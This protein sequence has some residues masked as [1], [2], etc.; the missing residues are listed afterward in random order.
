MDPDKT[1]GD[2]IL[3]GPALVRAYELEST[4]AIY[5]R[6]IIDPA[7]I[8]KTKEY[9]GSLWTEYIHRDEDGQLF[10][11]YLYGA[12]LDNLLT[13]DGKPINLINTLKLHKD[14]TERR[15]GSAGKEDRIR[16]KLQWL[17]SYHNTAVQRLKKRYSKLPDPFDIFDEQPMDI[18]DT[19][20]ISEASKLK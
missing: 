1:V 8:E 18:P 2:D 14:G 10:L 12:A 9:Q 11:D 6:I 20:F 4:A 15:L 7:V 17:V 13:Q 19:L 3:F 16:E 5:P